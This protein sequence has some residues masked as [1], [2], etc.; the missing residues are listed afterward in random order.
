M[1]ATIID[2]KAI[3]ATIREELAVDVS[4]F[5][6]SSGVTP[7]LAAVLVGDDPASAV[8]VR[9]KQRACEKTGIASTLHRLDADTSEDELLDLVGQLNNDPQIHGILCQLPLP[10]QISEQAV[11]DAVSPDKDVDCFHPENVGLIAQGRPR[12][13]PC[14]PHGIQ[15]LLVRTAVETSGAHVVV[16]GRSDIVGKPM[17]LLMVQKAEGANSTVTLCHSRTRNL[18]EIAATADILVAAIGR[19]RFV[20]A[21]MVKPGA[22][23]I[24]VGINRV[25]DKLVGDVDYEPVAEI[26]G[27]ITPVPGGVGPMTIAMLL[28]NTLTAARELHG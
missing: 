23:V 27:S 14:T 28:Q 6:A 9:N 20:T 24:D 26:A 11:L 13:L 19:A 3:A 7:H 8:Y 1:A 16:L 18:P 2:G 5:H 15:Q 12:F 25:D 22:V 4:A 21:E 17:G 10:E